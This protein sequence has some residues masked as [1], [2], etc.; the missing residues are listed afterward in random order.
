[1]VDNLPRILHS[2]CKAVIKEGNWEI[3]P[4]FR[5]L[6]EAGKLSAT[7]MRHTFNNGIGMVLAVPADAAQDVVS[8]LAAMD[9]KAYVIGEIVKRKKGEG[10]ISWS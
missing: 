4:I 1:M 7:E 2:S 6:Q 3:P 5:F 9:E 8:F 10:Q